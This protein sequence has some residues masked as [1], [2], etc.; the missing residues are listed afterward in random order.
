MSRYE[1]MTKFDCI[2][3]ICEHFHPQILEVIN[4]P[5]D[6]GGKHLDQ[7]YIDSLVRLLL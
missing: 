4:S 2:Q 6:R 5:R 1:G 7:H 3:L